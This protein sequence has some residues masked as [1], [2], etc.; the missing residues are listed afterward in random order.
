V[1]RHLIRYPA[2]TWHRVLVNRAHRR[3]ET[4]WFAPGT[5][6]MALEWLEK[7]YTRDSF[8]LWIDTFDPH[9]PWD[10]PQHYVDMYDPGYKGRVFEAP[11]YGLRKKMGITDRELQHIRARYAAEVTMVDTWF[12]HLMGAVERL[13][14]LD[15]TMVVFTSDHGTLFDGPGDNGILCKANTVGADGM[16]MA[17]GKP[18][19]QPHQYFPIYLNVARVPLAIRPPRLRSPARIRAIVQPWDMTATILDAFG[20]K[21]PPELI[22]ESHLGLIAGKTAKI[23]NTAVCGNNML[24]QAINGRWVY[25]A[26]QGQR[27]PSLIDRKNDPLAQENVATANPAVTKRLHGEIVRFMRRQ[28]IAEE[29]IAKYG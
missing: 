29:F 18:M 21:K 15:E 26:W 10:P 5:Y 25:T 7:N 14:L 13:G 24:A 17:G 16:C 28:G 11:T 1:P 2:D 9:E 12:G 6:S 4:D 27:E 19:P 3:V 22:G 8:F 23:R 20:M